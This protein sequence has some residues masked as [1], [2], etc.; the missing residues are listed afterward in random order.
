MIAL[1]VSEFP[2][3]I[4]VLDSSWWG[5][6]INLYIDIGFSVNSMDT[7]RF[8]LIPLVISGY[9]YVISENIQV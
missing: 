7:F 1:D 9:I 6:R 3:P 5:S 8:M 4:L 2:M